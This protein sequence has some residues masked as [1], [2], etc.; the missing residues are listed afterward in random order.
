ML[1]HLKKSMKTN[2][3][4]SVTPYLSIHNKLRTSSQT[5]NDHHAM[6]IV[7]QPAP[8]IITTPRNPEQLFI[9]GNRNGPHKMQQHFSNIN[10]GNKP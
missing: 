10:N 7:E 2:T 5:S 8:M 4:P 1:A 3:I 9:Q 6:A